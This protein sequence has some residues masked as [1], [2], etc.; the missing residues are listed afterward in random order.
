MQSWVQSALTC[1]AGEDIGLFLIV[2]KSSFPCARSVPNDYNHWQR[3]WWTIPICAIC[4][5]LRL[6][7]MDYP[8]ICKGRSDRNEEELEWLGGSRR[9]SADGGEQYVKALDKGGH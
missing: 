5:V 6:R 2:T 9:F 8:D 3:G 7:K 1:K 4:H